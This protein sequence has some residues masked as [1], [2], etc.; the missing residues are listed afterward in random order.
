MAIAIR[1][2]IL[3]CLLAILPAFGLGMA[4]ASPAAGAQG[5]HFGV[6]SIAPPSR[7][8]KNWQPFTEYLSAR[9][10]RPISIVVP[11]GFKKMKQA[12]ENGDVDFFYVNSHVF[13]RLKQE[14]KAVGVLQMKNILGETTSRSEIFVRKDS[15]IQ[16]LEQLRGK[17]IAYV[18]PMGAGGYLAPRAYLMSH[19]IKSG[20]DVEERFTKNLS[21]SIHNVLLE[22]SNAGT[23]CGVNFKLMSKKID[24]GELRVLAVSDPYPENVIAARASLDAQAIEAFR[25]AV[26]GMEDDPAGR[27]I[28]ADMQTMKIQA[29]IPYDP[30]IE[31]IT[32]KL[33]RQ[34]QLKH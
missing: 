29:F 19:N 18:S 24:M 31:K 13:Y 11:R 3:A 30:A 17:N 8:Y 25:Q 12:A 9:L 7:I 10:Q 33:L 6:L 4:T 14:G 34:A 27:A 20:Q 2:K 5:L 23:M 28:M 26:L 16:T 21:S 22:D 1:R 15:E 32:E